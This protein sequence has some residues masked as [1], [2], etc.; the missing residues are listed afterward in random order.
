MMKNHLWRCRDREIEI[1]PRAL[2]MGIVNVTPDSFSD[3]GRF[4]STAKAIEHGLRL[5]EDGAD[6][7]DIGGESSRPGA[8]AVPIDEELRRVIPVIVALAKQI[9]IP[10]SIDTAKAEVARQALRAGACIVNDIT[11]LGDP[12]MPEVVR[13]AGAGIVLM[14]MRGT[15]QTMHLNP[16]Y[17]DVVAEIGAFFEERIRLAVERG[18]SLEAIA[19]D[20]GI[21]FGKTL[22]HT[23]EQLRRLEEYQRFGR[24]V[25]L[26]VSRKG[27]I[28]QILNR[29]R[30]RRT[31]GSVAIAC[32]AIGRGAA[33]I[34]RVHDVAEHRDAAAMLQLLHRATS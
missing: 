15:P 13:A 31:A 9:A 2:I 8:E 32:H 7:L 24:P 28:G 10:I 19:L 11:A 1:G 25:C 5:V 16:A 6:I 22:E 27:F 12:E 23:L 14:H 18:I 3:G 33:Q 26:G 30:D 21:G 4:D 34:V 29:P 20:P 17:V